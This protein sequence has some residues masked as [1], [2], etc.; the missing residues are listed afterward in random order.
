[1]VKTIHDK[2]TTIKA[3]YKNGTIPSHVAVYDERVITEIQ[4]KSKE[5]CKVHNKS[6]D[7]LTEV[8]TMGVT[9][10][11]DFETP[12]EMDADQ[13]NFQEHVYHQD[14][15]FEYYKLYEIVDEYGGNNSM[16]GNLPK[17]EQQKLL[18]TY[19]KV[20][21]PIME[22]LNHQEQQFLQDVL[23][24]S[25]GIFSWYGPTFD[26]ALPYNY[27]TKDV[28]TLQPKLPVKSHKSSEKHHSSPVKTHKASVKKS[29]KTKKRP[30]GRA[31]KGKKWDYNLGE[32]TIDSKQPKSPQN[33]TKKRPRGR[34]PKGKRWD[35]TNGVWM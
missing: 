23:K 15:Y 8:L 33:K 35:Y 19:H 27:L 16:R 2:L 28:S 1:M 9:Y 17:K 20:Y 18:H 4:R 12:E 29:N 31:P 34:A 32:W 26:S 14:N 30:R 22:A 6:V 3:W 10:S 5:I 11:T 25:G 24:L 13:Y 7:F 21:V